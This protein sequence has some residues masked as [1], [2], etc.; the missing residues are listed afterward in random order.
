M[1][2]RLPVMVC[3]K[4]VL[5]KSQPI[6]VDDVVTYLIKSIELED[7]ANKDFDIGGPK[8]LTI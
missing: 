5:T 8:I 6:S 4:W 1:V 7:T 3:P 2:E